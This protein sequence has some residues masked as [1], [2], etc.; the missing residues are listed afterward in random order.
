MATETMV[1]MDAQTLEEALHNEFLCDYAKIVKIQDP[2][3]P[4]ILHDIKVIQK[5]QFN[6]KNGLTEEVIVLV[7]V[8]LKD[9]DDA[10]SANQS[11]L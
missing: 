6:N 1:G 4:L 3:N 2:N 8:T 7:P 10:N 11:Y 5:A 9:I